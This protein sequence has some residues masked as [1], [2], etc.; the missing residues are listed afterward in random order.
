MAAQERNVAGRALTDVL[1]AQASFA[2]DALPTVLFG[3]HGGPEAAV[4]GTTWDT[5]ALC[6][7]A[8][9]LARLP[10]SACSTLVL[11]SFLSSDAWL[12]RF[13]ELGEHLSQLLQRK[14]PEEQQALSTAWVHLARRVAEADPPDLDVGV[15]Q[16]SL[17]RRL[18]QG[19]SDY[20]AVAGRRVLDAAGQASL[21]TGLSRLL[22]VA[23]AV[24]RRGR[25][26]GHEP[27]LPPPCKWWAQISLLPS[28]A[29][30]EPLCEPQVQCNR[31]RAGEHYEDADGYL[32]V[33]FEL[34]REDFLRPLRQA[35][36]VLHEAS[37]RA[38]VEGRPWDSFMGEGELPR[39]VTVAA[40][41]F[42]LSCR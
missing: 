2:D 20:L 16:A 17:L 25:R 14:S 33:H 22:D 4:A 3:V 36:G 27:E 29:E 37:A 24:E 5:N 28:G 6:L 8:K 32:K 40:A 15:S 42:E 1:R 18:Q 21:R 34:L 38:T 30:L 23:D 31:V 35:V 41:E 10:E 9:L 7:S 13:I 39:E 26:A 11:H 19:V 12:R